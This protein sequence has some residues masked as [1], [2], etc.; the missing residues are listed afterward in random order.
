MNHTVNEKDLSVYL[1]HQKERGE[2]AVKNSIGKTLE[3]WLPGNEPNNPK[4]WSDWEYYG[5]KL[6][7]SR[8][9][10]DFILLRRIRLNQKPSRNP[11]KP[12]LWVNYDQLSNYLCHAY[13]QENGTNWNETVGLGFLSFPIWRAILIANEI[14]L[15]SEN[16]PHALAGENDPIWTLISLPEDKVFKPLLYAVLADYFHMQKMTEKTRKVWRKEEEKS[17]LKFVWKT[18]LWNSTRN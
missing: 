12:N 8:L 18:N 15:V 6:Q 14:T 10:P 9:I 4:T 1:R 13:G 7:S 3:E 16:D 11:G 17:W 2:E 5:L